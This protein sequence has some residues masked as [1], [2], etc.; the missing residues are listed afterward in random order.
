VDEEAIAAGRTGAAMRRLIDLQ[1]DRIRDLL[2]AGAPLG[3]QLPG[4]L[5][6][7]LRLILFGARRVFDRLAAERGDVFRRPRL[8][9]ADW[10][11]ATWEA[12]TKNSLWPQ[13]R[14]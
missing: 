7:E 4:R 8:T 2:V 9:R 13:T 11:G 14:R 3:W 6:L 1:L 10:L 5:G 12:V